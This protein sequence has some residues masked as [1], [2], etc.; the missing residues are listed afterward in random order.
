MTNHKSLFLFILT[1]GLVGLFIGCETQPTELE[2]YHPQAQLTCFLFNGQPVHE[3]WLERVASI[4]GPYHTTDHGILHADIRIF[5]GGDTLTL[6]DDPNKHG[7]YIPANGQTLVPRGKI[8]Y[9]IEAVVPDGEFL[10]AET[11]V[12]DTFAFVDIYLLLEDGTRQPVNDGDTLTRLDPNMFWEW[13]SVDS[14]GGYN[15]MI[16]ALT[17]RDSLVP[18]DPDWDAA[19]DSLEEAERTRA[20]FTVMRSDQKIITIPWIFFQW[21][22]P[23]RVELQAI[24]RDYYDYLFTSFR[25]QQGLIAEPQWNMHGGIGIFSGMSRYAI[26]VVMKK[27]T[28]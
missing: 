4:Y 22:G 5:G 24:S 9:R 1:L 27:V 21:A 6:V 17:P 11:V 25:V 23:Q 15:G 28:M 14:A 7:R 20:G 8:H 26:T 13:N 2:K 19:E 10:W 18:L 12:P 3:A 16:V